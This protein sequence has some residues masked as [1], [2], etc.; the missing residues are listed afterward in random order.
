MHDPIILSIL[1]FVLLIAFLASG[2]WVGIAIALTALVGFLI[3]EGSASFFAYVPYDTINSFVLTAI[4]LFIFMGEILTRCEISGMLYRGASKWLGWAPGGLLHSNIGACAL[5]AAISGSSVATAATMGTVAYPQ[6]E[7][8]GYD[9]KLTLGSLTGGGTLG[10]LIPP[11]I[12]M[13]IFGMLA[14]CSVGRLFAGGIIP[15]IILSAAFMTYIA[16]RA[17]KNPKLAP[18]EAFSLKG[19]L[20]SFKDFWPSMSLMIIVLGGIFGG[21]MT[22]TEAAAVG[23]SGALLIGLGLRKLSWQ[24]LRESILSSLQTTCMIMFLVAAGFI[25]ASL[26]GAIQLPTALLLLVEGSALPRMVILLLIFLLYLFFGCFIDTTTAIIMTSSVVIPLITALGFDIIWFGVTL[27]VLVE[28]GLLTPPFGLNLF[29]LQ[30]I[31][32]RPLSDV[33]IG[34]IPFFLI[35]LLGV[36]LF[37]AFPSLVLWL[38]SL[39]FGS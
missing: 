39:F 28:V 34:S 9:I 26:L 2:L 22:P 38:P 14:E 1:F 20:S 37:T 27:V 8:R 35:M 4:P 15:G 3:A 17:I 33:I 12:T 11:S 30:G 36:A 5:F 6:L 10:I 23:C 21:I 32:K 31:S 16:I 19:L 25:F 7:K 24:I 18:K 29:V 13:I